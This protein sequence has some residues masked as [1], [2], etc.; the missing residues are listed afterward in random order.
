LHVPLSCLRKPFLQRVFVADLCIVS[1]FDMG[2]RLHVPYGVLWNPR[3]QRVSFPFAFTA[4]VY[5]S[6]SL[7]RPENDFIVSAGGV[8]RTTYVGTIYHLRSFF[9]IKKAAGILSGDGG[10][11]NA[12]CEGLANGVRR[13]SG[14]RNSRRSVDQQIV[15]GWQ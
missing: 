14:N 1:A 8:Q 12:W 5:S 11:D 7:L 13:Q 9:L 10:A 2:F 3:R 15:V 6:S 4:G